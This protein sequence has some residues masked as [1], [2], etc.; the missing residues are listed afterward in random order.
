MLGKH[1][2][3]HVLQRQAQAGATQTLEQVWAVQPCGKRR[4]QR[5]G[6]GGGVSESGWEGGSDQGSKVELRG[7]LLAELESRGVN[8]PGR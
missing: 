1:M 4:L 7:W 2:H 8:G 5:G 3:A 6:K